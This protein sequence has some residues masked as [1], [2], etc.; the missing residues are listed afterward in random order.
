MAG[1]PRFADPV[2]FRQIADELKFGA[3]A[4]P[5]VVDWDRDGDNDILCGNTAGEIGWFEN[6]G[7]ADQT[8]DGLPRWSAPKLL[9]VTEN[10]SSKPF[11]V[12]AGHDGSIQGPAE[13]KWGY[14]TLTT[15]DIDR[16][17]DDDIVYNSILSRLGVLRRD[18]DRLTHELFD[19]GGSESPPSWYWWQTRRPDALTQ[20][21]TTPVLV[22]WDDDGSL[23]L[24][25]LD[26]EGYLTLRRSMGDAER[27]VR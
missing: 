5:H 12:M 26:Q 20:W 16:D 11:R 24:V 8:D 3:L 9:E 25:M 7:F 13:A 18:S 27:F 14:T 15:G 6:L 1:V 19:A 21:R 17:G 4:T 2:Y 10:A 23:D 22:D